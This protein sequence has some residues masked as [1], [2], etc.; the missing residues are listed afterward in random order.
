[1][2]NAMNVRKVYRF[3]SDGDAQTMKG[4]KC[5]LER[6]KSEDHKYFKAPFLKYEG[7]PLSVLVVVAR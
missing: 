2:Q 6:E 3:K 7:P 1:M 5:N 4:R